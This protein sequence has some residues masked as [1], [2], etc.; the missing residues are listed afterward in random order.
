MAISTKVLQPVLLNKSGSTER[1]CSILN[2]LH[3]KKKTTEKIQGT[4]QRKGLQTHTSMGSFIRQDWQSEMGGA[5][6]GQ[7]SFHQ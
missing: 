6:S 5:L 4:L 3:H 7:L 2:S 1:F